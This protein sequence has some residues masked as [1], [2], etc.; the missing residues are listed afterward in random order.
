MIS[1]QSPVL[2]P[3]LFLASRLKA[4]AAAI[5]ILLLPCPL[6]AVTFTV[7]NTNNSGAGSLRQAILDANATASGPRL[8]QFSIGSGAKTISPTS[9]LPP[10]ARWMEIDGSTQPGF[11]GTPLIEIN[12]TSAGASAAG[13]EVVDGEVTVRSLIINRFGGDGVRVNEAVVPEEQEEKPATNLRLFGCWIGVNAF[14]NFPAPN[15]GHGV[16]IMRSNKWLWNEIGEAGIEGRNVIS[17]NG[18]DGI[19][20]APEVRT[21]VAIYNNYIGIGANGLAAVGNDGDGIEPSPYYKD[22]YDLRSGYYLHTFGAVIGGT[23]SSRGNV[24]SA[25][26][27]HGI[28]IPA[29]TEAYGLLPIRRNLIGTDA[30][31]TTVRGNGGHGIFLGTWTRCLVGTDGAGNIIGGNTL[32]GILCHGSQIELN[33]NS[34]GTNTIGTDLG[35]GLHGLQVVGVWDTEVSD[36]TIGHNTLRGI[37]IEGEC[38]T[39]SITGS[40]IGTTAGGADIGNGSDGVYAA[41][42]RDGISSPSYGSGGFMG[43]AWDGSLPA[44][45]VAFNGGAGVRVQAPTVYFKIT[46]NEFWNNGGLAIDLGATG[47]TANDTGD[48]DTGPNRL[49]NFPVITLATPTRVIGRLESEANI[50]YVVQVFAAA[51]DA[52][53]H[54]EGQTLLGSE[55]ILTDA[56]GR[57]DFTIAGLALAPGT[58]VTATATAEYIPDPQWGWGVTMPRSS[59]FSQ[60]ATVISQDTGDFR[61]ASATAGVAESEGSVT[62]TVQRVGGSYGA[63]TV[64]YATSPGTAAS[65]TDFSAQ[66]GVLQFASGQTSRTITIPIINDAI[67]EPEETFTVTL[68]NPTGGPLITTASTTVTIAN[69]DSPPLVSINGTSVKEGNVGTTPVTFIVSLSAASAFPVSV[70]WTSSDVTATHTIDYTGGGSGTI[71]FA[72][73]ETQKNLSLTAVGDLT[74]ETNESFIVTLSSPVNATLGTSTGTGFILDDD[75]PGAIQ[76]ATTSYSI[77]EASETGLSIFIF[78]NGGGGPVTVDYAVTGGTAA[79]HQDYISFDLPGTLS[80]ASGETVKQITLSPF[81]D[82]FVEGHET[83]I[84]SLSNP[85]GGATLG[86][87]SATTV[88]ILDDDTE[89]TLHGRVAA[90]DGNPLAGATVSLTGSAS[91][92]VTTDSN[93]FYLFEKLPLGGDYTV[94]PSFDGYVFTPGSRF[95]QSLSNSLLDQNFTATIGE[96]PTLQIANNGNGTITLTWPAPS[97]GWMLQR[98]TT[99]EPESWQLVLIPPQTIGEWKSLVLPIAEDKEFFRLAHP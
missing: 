55:L 94:T 53:G 77:S 18:G 32:S 10:L 31:G 40:R 1:L 87:V 76:F 75:S 95:F 22:E 8:I 4:V 24:I 17:G 2:R 65:G 69:D 50:G 39:W 47:V 7:T 6:A 72:P 98:S 20:V 27:G 34:I 16:H 91:A 51:P 81:D 84:I 25:N 13:L 83:I 37:S 78:R 59:E 71:H 99:M 82:I 68:S 46:G 28:H 62:L 70:T 63:A 57:G 74:Q 48:A 92:T 11:N 19:H 21:G 42:F 96:P 12:G 88:T 3:A 9:P 36:C 79:A 30:N 56:G 85:T 23:T 52:S 38:G 45:K 29:T 5:P 90:G 66:S 86:G 73:G 54:G 64:N 26:G 93:G 35:N 60:N 43:P 33:D 15:G 58:R 80:F 49:Q 14:G 97:T 67:Q 61:M 44:N 41:A 89:V